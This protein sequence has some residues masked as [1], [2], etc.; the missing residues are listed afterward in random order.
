MYDSIY[1]E[2]EAPKAPELA[3]IPN[4]KGPM[5]E[6]V[7]RDAAMRGHESLNQHLVKMPAA[8]RDALRQIMPELKVLA[9][10]GDRRA[11]QDG[12]AYRR[13]TELAPPPDVPNSEE[14]AAYAE[15]L[16]Q[17]ADQ[18]KEQQ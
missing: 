12:G 11:D 9:D 14:A 5:A 8:Q 15:W 18:R 13:A 6:K 3:P 10:E 17:T 1:S 16:A 4:E 7:A 2:P